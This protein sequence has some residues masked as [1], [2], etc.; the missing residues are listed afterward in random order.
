MAVPADVSE[1]EEN[2]TQ[3]SYL[4]SRWLFLRCLGLIHLVAFGSYAF[5]II[6]LNGSHGIL[7]SV[8][9]LE[10]YRETGLSALQCFMQCPTLLWINGTDAFLQGITVAGV[11]LSVFAVLGIATAPCLLLL[12]VL[13]LSLVKGGCEFTGFQSDGML[14]ELTVLTLFLVPWQFF[15]PPWPVPARFRLQTKPSMMALWLIRFMLFRIMFVSGLVKILSGDENWRNLT[16][17]QYHYETQPIPTPLAWYAHH[18]PDWINKG[19]VLGMFVS[20]IF[21]P[22]CMFGPRVFKL[23]GA[24]MMALLHFFIALTGNYTFLSFLMITLCITLL[25]DELLEK[26][27]PK[28]L[29]ES[30]RN[31]VDNRA[32]GIIREV[33][34]K[35]AMSLCFAVAI[36]VFLGSLYGSQVF[37][38]PLRPL[39]AIVSPFELC[40]SYGL[41]AVMTTKRS[42]IVFQGSNDGKI[43]LT[44]EFPNKPG[45]DL[46]QAPPWVAPHMPRLDWRLWFAAM[47]PLAENPWIFSL[48]KQML[49]GNL[50]VTKYF[51]VNPFPNTPPK[52]IRA[53]VY[54]YHFSTPEQKAA[55]GN[56]WWRDKQG[57][58]L[59]PVV[60]NNG[61][62]EPA[63]LR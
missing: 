30:I 2:K 49:K 26:V 8:D 1:S 31:S 45:D 52:Y 15:E 50:E 57:V 38:L 24:G 35:G 19:S 6:G 9:L 42:E 63:D 55:T 32:A 60:L 18:L 39:I 22:L 21:A 58:Y 46:K 25:D 54:D 23:L 62:V 3:E 13:W 36:S 29:T 16:A 14:V 11:I 51:L 10:Q 5:Q 41:F 4:L 12:S 17:M 7:P 34:Y 53:F 56:W 27:F 20:E 43:W 59:D 61:M 40:N 37:L 48:V 47:V 33:P 44:Y 28:R